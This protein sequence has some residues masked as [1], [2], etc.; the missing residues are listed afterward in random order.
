M[1]PSEMCV[2]RGCTKH[3]PIR[4]PVA[5]CSAM[6]QAPGSRSSYTSQNSIVASGP[7]EKIGGRPWAGYQAL[8]ET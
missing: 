3:E 7:P 2:S 1:M 4:R 5:P 8:V 6:R